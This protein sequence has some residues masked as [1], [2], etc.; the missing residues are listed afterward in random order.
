MAILLPF[1]DPLSDSGPTLRV[2]LKEFLIGI[3]GLI[4]ARTGQIRRD[5][6]SAG[7]GFL[8]PPRVALFPDLLSVPPGTWRLDLFPR[9]MLRR[10]R[11]VSP[12]FEGSRSPS[13]RVKMLQG[14]RLRPPQ[15][16]LN[17]LPNPIHG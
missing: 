12:D 10:G 14:A 9:P 17:S 1:V 5:A 8:K 6:S 16:F 4:P 7:A 13:P 15:F 11:S 3:A 2:R